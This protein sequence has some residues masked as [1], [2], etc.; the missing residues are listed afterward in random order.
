M[1]RRDEEDGTIPSTSQAAR[2]RVEAGREDLACAADL[3]AGAPRLVVLTGAGI[4]TDSGIPDYRGPNGTWT[5]DPSAMRPGASAEAYRSDASLRA[6]LWQ[7]RLGAPV[8]AAQPNAAHES[9]VAL[10]RAGRL[11]LLVTQNTDG[12]H[13]RAGQD[14]SLVVEVHGTVRTTAC[15]ACPA[16]VPTEEVLE[17]VRAGERDPRC[18]APVGDGSCGGALR[19]ATVGFGQPVQPKAL[20]RAAA[21]VRTASLLLVVGSTLNVEPV[22]GLVPLAAACGVPTVILNRGTTRHDAL[23]TALVD[24]PIGELLPRLLA[25]GS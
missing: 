10:E 6:R 19:V 8:W 20:T 16:E 1:A 21:A 18:R 24:G 2:P 15:L 23:A 12:L 25:T 17:R 5:R 14:P 4:S 13:L 22:A 7:N 9:L 11:E 3:V